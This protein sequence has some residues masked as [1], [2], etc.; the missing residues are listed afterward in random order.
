MCIFIFLV[1]VINILKINKY[2]IFEVYY[3]FV[4]FF[5]DYFKLYWRVLNIDVKRRMMRLF[6]SFI[7]YDIFF[8]C[9]GDVGILIFK[10]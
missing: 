2:V 4:Y 6:C 9:I 3:I 8:L 10:E 1:I 5:F 7:L